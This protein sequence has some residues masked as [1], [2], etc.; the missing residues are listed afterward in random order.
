MPTS[1][2]DGVVTFLKKIATPK[3][4]PPNTKKIN[5]PVAMIAAIKAI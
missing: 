5:I 4:I 1:A 2:E 3:I